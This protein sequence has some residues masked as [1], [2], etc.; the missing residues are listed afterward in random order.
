MSSLSISISTADRG[1]IT[2]LYGG[3]VVTMISVVRAKHLAVL[4]GHPE[5]QNDF[6]CEPI[7]LAREDMA[8]RSES[9]IVNKEETKTKDGVSDGSRTDQDDD[10]TP[11]KPHDS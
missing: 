2:A 3:I 8:N 4:G 10:S 6:H 5:L 9:A 1:P 11:R 7:Q